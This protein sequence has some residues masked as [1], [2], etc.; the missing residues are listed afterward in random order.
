MTL[1]LL[2]S[3]LALLRKSHR[4][5]LALCA[6]LE[7]IADDLPDRVDR[8]RCLYLARALCPIITEAH[9][10]EERAL[11]PYL[12]LLT[13]T[14]PNLDATI[15]RL[16]WEHFEDFCFSEELR[17]ALFDLGRGEHRMNP[18]TLGYMLRCFFESLRRHIAFEREM[19]VP[20][21]EAVPTQANRNGTEAP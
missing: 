20:A 18:E 7:E 13:R 9:A 1:A 16:R 3:D 10:L 12:R 21:C 8:Q 17:D 19:L 11:F 6:E 15:E 4:R 5:Q 2:T 14:L